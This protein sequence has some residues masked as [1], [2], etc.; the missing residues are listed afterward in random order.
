MTK[1]SF[2]GLPH[3]DLSDLSG[4]TAAV[5]GIPEASPYEPIA[6]SHSAAAPAAI[7][8]GSV[9]FGRIVQ[10]FDFDSNGPLI[11]PSDGLRVVD[12]GDLEVKPETAEENRAAITRAIG[13]MLDAGTVPI[14]LGG[15]DSV[16]IPVFAAYEGRGD[17]TILQ[18]DAHAD[19]GDSIR[20]NPYGYGST[21][22]R[23]SEC[24]CVRG[25]V[26]VGLRGLG[27]GEASQIDDARNWGARLITA[28]DIRRHGVDQA[29]SLIPSDADVLLAIDCDGID[30]AVF[31]AVNMPTPGGLDYH[32]VL[33]IVHGIAGRARLAGCCLV[34]FVPEADRDGL[35]ALTAAGIVRNVIAAIRSNPARQ[36]G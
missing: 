30:P 20:G 2:A 3:S 11:D 8:A 31:P 25:I 18:I 9:R 36:R 10:H 35:S 16:P 34:E 14:V 19:W 26:Q 23:A 32:D 6:P 12:C 27:S 21:M 29:L 24:P 4:V 28:R 22:R 1:P 15:D 13:T 5:I 7:R 17:L 33:E